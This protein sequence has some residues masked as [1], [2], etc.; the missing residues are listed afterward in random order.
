MSGS[1][2]PPGTAVRGSTAS[3]RRM[4]TAMRMGTA[5]S[6]MQVRQ[7]A[8]GRQAHSCDRHKQLVL[9][10]GPLA[11]LTPGCAAVALTP[12]PLPRRGP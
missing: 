10:A 7:A 1:V 11:L 5:S 2:Q 6:D 4:G 9:L 8:A 12:P 3:S